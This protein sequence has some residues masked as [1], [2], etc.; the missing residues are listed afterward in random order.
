MRPA[1]VVEL[2]IRCPANC[3]RLI[4]HPLPFSASIPDMPWPALHPVAR[5]QKGSWA[6]SGFGCVTHRLELGTDAMCRE[7]RLLYERAQIHI[8]QRMAQRTESTPL[9]P[10]ESRLT[11]ALVMALQ[12]ER[13]RRREERDENGERSSFADEFDAAVRA[14]SDDIAKLPA[15]VGGLVSSL[16]ASVLARGAPPVRGRL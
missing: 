9:E 3:Q 16:V 15:D 2:A 10:W 6:P 12:P 5:C 7:G 8:A 4:E 1:E 14:M 13:A 11:A